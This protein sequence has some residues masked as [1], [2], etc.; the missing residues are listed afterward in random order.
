MTP[1]GL[2]VDV[3]DLRNPRT[4]GRHHNDRFVD[5]IF[6]PPERKLVMGA[7]DPE[8]ALWL[9]WAAKEAAFKA[10]GSSVHPEPP[11]IFDHSAVAVVEVAGDRA[12]VRWGDTRIDL[13]LHVDPRGRWVAA[14]GQVDRL[15][16]AVKW[17]VEEGEETAVRLGVPDEAALHA[18]LTPGEVTASRGFVHALVRLAART[19][20]ASRMEVEP[21]RLEIVSPRG[22]A[23]R[24]PPEVHLDGEL[25]D[26][27]RVSLSHDG[28]LIAWATSVIS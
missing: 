13:V 16:P 8:R 2:G 19:E 7:T 20:V 6:D 3:V 1:P 9:H 15:D 26:R 25:S 17:S 23:G 14:L 22:P 10:V 5:R 24:V 28:P 12:A 27:V 21:D 18:R 11:P 4:R